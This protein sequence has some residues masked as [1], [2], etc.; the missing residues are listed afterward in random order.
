[1]ILLSKYDDKAGSA[2]SFPGN[3]P[4]RSDQQPWAGGYNRVAVESSSDKKSQSVKDLGSCRK[5]F[6]LVR[7][8]NAILD[9]VPD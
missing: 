7:I 2:G 3:R 9:C 4:V 8:G 6:W 5:I 1:M